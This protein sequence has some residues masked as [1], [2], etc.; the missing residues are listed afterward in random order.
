MRLW[1]ATRDLEAVLSEGVVRA[2]RLPDVYAFDDEEAARAYALEF[3]Y[4]AVVEVEAEGA[5]VVRRWAPSYAQGAR[6]V[7]LRGPLRV[8][9]A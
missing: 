2:T 9:T 3:G 4:A 5:Q 1:H 7:R 6:V 8:V